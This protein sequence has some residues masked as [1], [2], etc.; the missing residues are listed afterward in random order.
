MKFQRS[1][2]DDKSISKSKS[3]LSELSDISKLDLS[4]FKMHEGEFDSK[5]QH[6]TI[7][8][9]SKSVQ[10]ARDQ[11]DNASIKLGSFKKTKFLFP[12]VQEQNDESGSH[13]ISPY[14]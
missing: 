7:I 5:S 8:N 9:E 13:Q 11:S 10:S 4:A 3:D 12:P 14:K 1:A 2:N 6:I